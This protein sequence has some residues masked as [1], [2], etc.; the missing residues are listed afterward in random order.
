MFISF[1]RIKDNAMVLGVS[2][3]DELCRV[4][5]HGVLHLIGYNDKTDEEQ[6]VMS[7]KENEMLKLR[8]SFT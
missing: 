8:H 1:D 5:V 4:M 2:S 7:L 6:H 3:F